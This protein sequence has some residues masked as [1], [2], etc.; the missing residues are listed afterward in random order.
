MTKNGDILNINE[1][2]ALDT[3]L[4]DKIA[5]GKDYIKGVK[6]ANKEA[7]VETRA[8]VD[9]LIK[10]S[11][12]DAPNYKD[13]NKFVNR[14]KRLSLSNLLAP[15]SN[16]DFEGLLYRLLPKGANRLAGL[17]SINETLLDPLAKANVEY[18]AHKDKLRSMWDINKNAL[19]ETGQKI[20]DQT[21]IEIELAEGTHKLT[22]GEAVKVYN[23]AKDPNLYQQLERGGF[24]LDALNQ[25]V[26]YIQGNPGLRAY[27]NGI[28]QAYASVAPAINNKLNEH[29]RQTFTSP[30]IDKD[31]LTPEQKEMMEKLYG[32]IPANAVYTPVTAEGADQATDIDNLIK[33]GNYAMYSV[34]DGRLKNRTRGG[35]IKI[36]GKNPD[37]EFESYLRGPV[38][39]LAFL[40][41]AKNASNFFGKDQLKQMKLKYGDTW[42]DAM[43]DSLKRIVT[44]QNVPVRQ[45]NEGKFIEKLLQR[46]VGG[47]MFFNVRSALLQHLSLFNYMFEDVGSMR[48]G[49]VAPKRVKELVAEKMKPY[50]SDRGKGR[51]EL[52]VD[53]LFGRTNTN[54]AD[55]LVEK[56]YNLTKWGDKN[57]ISTGGG[58]FMAGKFMEYS[59]TLP[60]AEALDKAY[61]D[62]VRVTEETQQSTLP[63]RLGKQQTTA[64]GR[65]VLAFANTP[66]QYN[67]KISR[68]IQ[69]LKGLRGVS[70]PEASARKKKA[71]GE[72]MWYMGMQNAIFTSLQ[73]LSFAALGLDAG[74]E[75][76]RATN[77]ANSLV[78]TL[79]RGAGIY[80]AL[81]AT[82]KDAI[83]AVSRDKDI[84]DSIVNTVP[85]LGNLVRNLK[86]VAGQKPIYPKSEL[87]DDFDQDTAKA[88]YQT[89]AGLTA[90][91][92]P[93]NKAL[94]IVEQ[95]ADVV[96][97]DL[98]LLDRLARAAGYERYQIDETLPGGPLK[99]QGSPFNRC[100]P[101]H[102]DEVGEAFK[103]GTI[104]VDPNLSPEEKAK[105]IKHEEQHVRDMDSGLL[106]YD[107]NAVYYDGTPYKRKEGKI[108]YNGSWYKEGDPNLP[109]EA[110]AYE[111]EG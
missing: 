25:V 41:F 12:K 82:A 1:L 108:E 86:T 104:K 66:Q 37:S 77:W 22:K 95:V 33:D 94:K 3:I 28:T 16:N 110:R 102:R 58:P 76:D 5:E 103:D 2:A 109:W 57:A 48:R 46:Q 78:N 52:L 89:A 87:L 85:S 107:D 32:Y 98:D 64:I 49:A 11:S 54:F 43:K 53:E 88:I 55:V 63:E 84:A 50:L 19:A 45:T 61:Q 106:N 56:G 74:D 59:K 39:T 111:V 47:I 14:V 26:D 83:I 91:G 24:D 44:G 72:V 42:S 30:R 13:R 75:D 101:F 36:A 7:Q 17:K 71:I 35:E 34:M 92:Y 93:G 18:L 62:F 81:V 70:G 4:T 96:S 8:T 6:K 27:A 80:G 20:T 65:Y 73:S 90:A 97:S 79:L 10:N 100:G 23:Y 21:D 105:T 29:G 51:T 69:D 60:E 15:A 67:R 68:A 40:D 99:R 9:G 38:R 31:A